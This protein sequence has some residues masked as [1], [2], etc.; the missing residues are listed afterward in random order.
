MTS[1]NKIYAVWLYVSDLTRSIEFYRDKVG[2]PIKFITED[3]WVE[4]DLGEA[5]FAILKR[6]E[7]KGR[8]VPQKT[9]IMFD[10]NNIEQIKTD[11]LESGINLIG[12]IRYEPYGKL[13]TI[14]DPDGH[15]LECY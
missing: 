9:R 5:S 13:L 3:S 12:D 14:E 6:P 4:F 15:W 10:V 1:I 2:L 7:E 11:F 8:V